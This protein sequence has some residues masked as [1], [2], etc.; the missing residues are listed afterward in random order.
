MGVTGRRIRHPDH[1]FFT[2]SSLK[3]L[4]PPGVPVKIFHR[5][6]LDLYIHYRNV[7]QRQEKFGLLSFNSSRNEPAV[8]LFVLTVPLVYGFNNRITILVSEIY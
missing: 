6:Q 3:N 5:I 4:G 7:A 2:T 1:F 8:F